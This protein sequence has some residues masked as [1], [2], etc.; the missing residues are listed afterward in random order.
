MTDSSKLSTAEISGFVTST[1]E[2]IERELGEKDYRPEQLNQLIEAEKNGKDR[3]KVLKKLKDER[4]KW[5]IDEDLEIAE[6]EIEGLRDTLEDLEKKEEIDTREKD[7]RDIGETELIE[8]LGATVKELRSFVEEEEINI[9]GLE[10]MLEGEK[11]VKDRKSAKEFLERK[12]KERR[13]EIDARETEKDVEKLEKDLEGIREDEEFSDFVEEEGEEISEEED[14][15]KEKEEKKEGSQASG[16]KKEEMGKDESG[17]GPGEDQG[18]EEKREMVEGLD[19]EFGD[20]ELEAL[21]PDDLEELVEE[22]KRREE[23]I[24]GLKDEG[25]DEDDLSNASNSDLEK[26]YSQVKDEQDSSQGS[27]S[28]G[29]EDMKSK[30]EI[31]EEAEEDLEML[32]GAGKERVEEED[33]LGRR[34]AAEE[35]IKGLRENLKNSISRED[36]E[37]ESEAVF[38]SEKVV[39]KLES[40]EGLGDREAAVKTAHILKAYLEFRVGIDKEMTYDEL[41]DNLPVEEYSEM[42]ELADFFNQMQRDEYTKNIHIGNMEEVIDTAKSVIEELER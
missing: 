32:M 24:S 36:S 22:E 37:D 26:L 30:E 6:G 12:L 11:K 38:S 4:K 14:E 35:K 10:Q 8:I 18:L 2:E 31:R 3:K 23:L 17:E 1:T 34:E 28:S 25:L 33:D 19:T 13:I 20:E 41:A 40:Y 16:E 7:R 29:D 39:D 21:S 5:K 15:E 9:E 42:E 27:E